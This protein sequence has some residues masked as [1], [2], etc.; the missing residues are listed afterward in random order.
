MK[1]EK[2]NQLPV[3]QILGAIS[4]HKSVCIENMVLW[5]TSLEI[6]GYAGIEDK[7][8]SWGDSISLLKWNTM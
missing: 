6:C 2:L 7:D 3:S 8:S 5:E 1:T 4:S